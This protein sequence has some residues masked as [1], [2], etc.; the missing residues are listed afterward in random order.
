MQEQ[1]NKKITLCTNEITGKLGNEAE[2]ES[3]KQLSAFTAATAWSPYLFER[4]YKVNERTGKKYKLFRTKKNFITGHFFAID[5]D[6]GLSVEEAINR[7]NKLNLRC[8]I[9]TTKSHRVNGNGDKFRIVCELTRPLKN[10]DEVLGTFQKLLKD[11]PEMD[12]AC[13]D[14]AR[15]FKASPNTVYTNYDGI[16]IE[17]APPSIDPHRIAHHTK[18]STIKGIESEVLSSKFRLSLTTMKFLNEPQEEGQRHAGLVAACNNAGQQG[19]SE[20]EFRAI[21]N[22]NVNPWMADPKHDAHITDIF[23]NKRW[24]SDL[25]TLYKENVFTPTPNQQVKWVNKWLETKNAGVTYDGMIIING[26]PTNRVNVE[27]DIRLHSSVANVTISK[28]IIEDVIDLYIETKRAQYLLGILGKLNE[29]KRVD[30][31]AELDKFLDTLC[32]VNRK[33]L[34]KVILKHFIWNVKRRLNGHETNREIMPVIQ[35]FQGIGKSYTIRDGLLRPLQD[36]SKQ[37]TFKQLED[38]REYKLLSDNFVLFFDEMSYA[39]LADIDNIK[40][41]ITETRISIRRMYTSSHD[42]VVKNAQFIGCTNK[43]LINIITD[44]TGMRRF[45]EIVCR[46]KSSVSNLTELYKQL[47]NID[48]ELIWKC[49][50]HEDEPPVYDHITELENLQENYVTKHPIDEWLFDS[51][52]VEFTDEPCTKFNDIVKALNEWT[53]GPRTSVNKLGRH[54]TDPKF[55][56]IIKKEKRRDGLFL[57]LKLTSKTIKEY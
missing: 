51:G 43:S 44:P 27:R 13:K 49:V 7:V 25:P 28:G 30:A 46:P 56:D 22:Y 16:P 34:D 47:N 35:G 24:E 6:E 1:Y 11:F 20:A 10:G 31:D 15:F 52:E 23:S 33:P 17:P 2:V 42:I 3:L 40:R 55:D 18:Q 8:Y 12:E 36:L 57:N 21:I 9:Q 14:E 38:P 26:T 45:Y 54:L 37:S 41:L 50:S 32:G 53:Q 4:T 5:V 39:G 29:V 19:W 48:Y